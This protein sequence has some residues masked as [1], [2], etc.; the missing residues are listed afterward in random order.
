M[1]FRQYVG[2]LRVNEAK[3]LLA[4]T[5]MRISE[6]GDACGFS[7]LRTFDRT[8]TDVTGLTPLAYREKKEAERH[9]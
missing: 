6:I 8:F 1:S 2:L 7:C 5:T 4:D 3:S 9:T